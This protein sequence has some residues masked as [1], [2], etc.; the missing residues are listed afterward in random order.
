MAQSVVVDPITRIEGH[1]SI[2]V[3]V[4]EGR[5]ISA[6]SV[7]ESFRGFEAI[8]KG[9]KPIDAQYI[10]QR[11]CGV[12]PVE[13]AIASVLAQDE[14]CG[15]TPPDNGRLVRNIVAAANFIQSHILHFYTLS[16]IDFIDITAVLQYQGRDAAMNYL[17]GWVQSEIN[18]T[19]YYPAAPFLP[20]ME[21][22]YATDLDLNLGAIKNYLKA[23]EMRSEASKLGAL[24]GGKI[25]HVASIIPGGATIRVGGRMIADCLTVI[26]QL[27]DFIDRCYVPDV[28]AVAEGFPDY[29]QIG[30]GPGNF[31]AYGVFHENASGSSKLLPSGVLLDG[32]M[33]DLDETLITED[34]TSAWF[35]AT[36][37]QHP[38]D[39]ETNPEPT[40]A[41]AYS[42]LKAPRYDGKVMEVGP[43]ARMLITY[44]K[45]GNPEVTALMN[46]L[47]QTTGRSL[48]EL[49][50]V[51][52][53]HAARAI[54]CKLI[55]DRT[56]QWIQ[57]L[58]PDVSSF[59]SF[60][61][62]ST[63]QGVGLTEAARGALGHWMKISGGVIEN[64]QCV[65]PTTWNASPRDAS[66]QPGA[67]EQAL[68]GTPIANNES[69][70]ETVRVV[71]SFDPCL[72][73]AVH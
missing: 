52:G 13:H 62:P 16:A 19:N 10:T 36:S 68:V 14:A 48:T 54:E 39:G 11:I 71:R 58:T 26:R 45:G 41:G 67:I 25:P 73:C 12:C 5:V 22:D 40:K 46:H 55:A 9:R 49:D 59:S 53:R 51:L 60:S 24:L 50:S 7:G 63:G 2:R 29:Y 47:L 61:V 37:S 4:E 34:V 3:E 56:E 64:Y 38:Y 31:L 42:W 43:L 30:K 72:S 57:Q 20:R 44:Q 1:L 18:S 33:H 23:L 35:T 27:R 32:T 6:E 21:G 17:K 65:V 8:L 15:V 66:G 70:V 69:P 28:L